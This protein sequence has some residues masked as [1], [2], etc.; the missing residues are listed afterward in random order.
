MFCVIVGAPV[1][2]G[3]GHWIAPP[4]EPPESDP[5]LLPELLDPELLPLL[6]PELLDPEPPEEPLAPELPVLP[7]LEPLLLPELPPSPPVSPVPPLPLELLHATAPA[8]ATP[9]ARPPIQFP[10]I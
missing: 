4:S 7:E 3:F 2:L 6:L 10:L 8:R 9:T 1:R 5:L